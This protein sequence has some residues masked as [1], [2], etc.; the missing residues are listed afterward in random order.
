M[1]M[2]TLAIVSI[3]ASIALLM[4]FGGYIAKHKDTR[5]D[6][7]FYTLEERLDK[8][9]TYIGI[10][11]NSVF[12]EQYQHLRNELSNL[13]PDDINSTYLSYCTSAFNNKSEFQNL[14]N[15]CDEAKN[16]DGFSFSIKSAGF[17]SKNE[18]RF[19]F[20][21][22][23]LKYTSG[24][25]QGQPPAGEVDT[26]NSITTDIVITI[27]TINITSEMNP[28]AKH[29][30]IYISNEGITLK[31][32]HNAVGNIYC[33]NSMLL[34]ERNSKVSI[35]SN[36]L[37]VFNTLILRSGTLDIYGSSRTAEIRARDIK[38]DKSSNGAVLTMIG[39]VYTA[40]DLE[41]NGSHG[42]VSLFGTYTGFGRNDGVKG[43]HDS[44]INVNGQG[45][46]LDLSGVTK[47]IIGGNAYFPLAYSDAAAVSNPSY[48]KTGE[49]L[50]MLVN[51][52]LHQVYS[53]YI[54]EAE[55]Y[56]DDISA[57][58]RISFSD[59]K[60]ANNKSLEQYISEGYT[61][62][63]TGVNIKAS[64][65]NG[66]GIS[67][68]DF[69]DVYLAQEAVPIKIATYEQKS[70]KYCYLYWDFKND[71][72]REEF[73]SLCIQKGFAEQFLT[74]FLDLG[75]VILNVESGSEIY[76]E[77]DLYAYTPDSDAYKAVLA[78]ANASKTVLPA[79]VVTF[80][81][82]CRTQFEQYNKSL[83]PST[84]VTAHTLASAGSANAIIPNY[85]DAT[86][87]TGKPTTY[88]PEGKLLIVDGDLRI[89]GGKITVTE[90]GSSVSVK[91]SDTTEVNNAVSQMDGYGMIITKGSFI[92]D[93][94]VMNQF[95]GM[96]ISYKGIEITGGTYTYD[97][98]TVVKAIRATKGDSYS[99]IWGNLF[100]DKFFHEITS[101][102][103]GETSFKITD[104]MKFEN[105]MKNKNA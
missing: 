59:I 65:P 18:R 46:T 84:D 60:D 51:E 20:K 49:A 81:G 24:T 52:N 67:G 89:S 32:T 93:S 17:D 47:L 44:A 37:T 10:E 29:E 96:I 90:N 61:V 8:I 85:I 99:S 2:I 58:S 54:H 62:V 1:V 19:V 64:S 43:D 98:S 73:I 21:D 22:V 70:Y 91:S 48:Y 30:Y 23:C 31:G 4:S 40:D 50:A 25:A 72:K 35:K 71:V 86:T 56:V 9:Y 78:K 6:K 80:I 28:D 15:H 34:G 55:K 3:F 38:T 39:D 100:T 68:T 13:Q 94:S 26:Y 102:G 7:N 66:L 82:T 92:S 33:G 5:S 11:A 79:D 95:N 101:G 27:P 87:M 63:S 76:A 12:V 42:A 103:M 45:T 97:S 75:Q 77:T 104:F 69:Y 41:I 74:N 36:Y 14:S 105:W 16:T 53:G 83:A 57:N 88:I